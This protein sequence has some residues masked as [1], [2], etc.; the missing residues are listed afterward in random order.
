MDKDIFNP[1]NPSYMPDLP[2]EPELCGL[3]GNDEAEDLWLTTIGKVYVCA[4]CLNYNLS[5]D[6]LILIEKL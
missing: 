2:K 1:N 6:T 4:F 5:E 3:C